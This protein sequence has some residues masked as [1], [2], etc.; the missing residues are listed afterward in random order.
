[1]NRTTTTSTS[2]RILRSS[3]RGASTLIEFKI[4]V[5]EPVVLKV[6]DVFGREVRT[7]LLAYSSL[8]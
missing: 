8:R 7:L 5:K 2:L 6:F 4:P 3:F 1:M